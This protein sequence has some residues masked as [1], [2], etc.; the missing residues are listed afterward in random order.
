MRRFEDTDRG[1]RTARGRIPRVVLVVGV[2]VAII[3]LDAGAAMAQIVQS[4]TENEPGTSETTQLVTS[5]TEVRR[6]VIGLMVLAFLAA[7]VLMAYWYKTGQEARERFRRRYG[8]RHAAGPTEIDALEP[9]DAWTVAHAPDLSVFAHPADVSPQPAYAAHADQS[10]SAYPVAAASPSA[11]HHHAISDAGRHMPE[12]VPAASS[13]PMR[14]PRE[15]VAHQSRPVWHTPAPH[16]EPEWSS[17]YP[18]ENG[19]GRG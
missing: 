7:I 6:A 2:A 19:F 5:S 3:V 17:P 13:P 12:A 1:G 16:P 14:S 4:E 9:H 10:R 11:R 18:D 8:G 15:D